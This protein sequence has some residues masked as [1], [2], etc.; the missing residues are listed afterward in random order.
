MV[1]L[2]TLG[3]LA[4]LGLLGLPDY[5]KDGLRTHSE[6]FSTRTDPWSSDHDHDGLLDGFEARHGLDPRRADPDGDGLPDDAELAAGADPF[7]WD[8]DHD[9]LNDRLEVVLGL[10]PVRPDSDDDGLPDAAEF[11]FGTDPLVADTDHDGL[12]DGA[13]SGRGTRPLHP[14]SDGDW[15]LDGAEVHRHRTDP[16]DD[17]SDDDLLDDAREVQAA[18][19]PLDADTDDDGLVDGDEVDRHGTDPLRADTDS[20]GLLDPA[21]LGLGS[22]PLDPDSDDD[23]LMDGLEPVP[24][25]FVADCD[26]DG[27]DDATEF[28]LELDLQDA[29]TVGDLLDTTLVRLDLADASARADT[30]GDGIPDGLETSGLIEW[31]PFRPQVG[32]TDYLVEMV[33]VTTPE[34]AGLDWASFGG[35]YDQVAEA[36]QGG[37]IAMQW[38][39]TDLAVRE[40]PR[41]F[42][43]DRFLASHGDHLISSSN[44]FVHVVLLTPA[45]QLTADVG[46]GVGGW[47]GYYDQHGLVVYGTHVLV[48]LEPAGSK[49]YLQLFPQ[50][51]L[52]ADACPGMTG[53]YHLPSQRF[54]LSWESGLDAG[55]VSWDGWLVDDASG[56]LQ[57]PGLPDANVSVGQYF[58]A[59]QALADTILHEIG[60]NM[61]LCHTHEEDCYTSLP[62]HEQAL[63]HTSTM[64]YESD[65][66]L[67]LLPSQWERFRT[68]LACSHSGNL[69]ALTLGGLSDYRFTG[70]EPTGAD[71]D[72][73]DPRRCG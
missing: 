56:Q 9:G 34:T 67:H 14:D 24:C 66:P 28:G 17:D 29:T 62:P 53:T 13:E 6:V 54:S 71:A 46:Q 72:L 1:V 27:V 70:E 65:F 21:E 68:Q 49:E 8:T 73:F 7:Q 35:A 58:L 16:L 47:A 2:I 4:G 12:M 38:T 43:Q 61:G 39:E 50:Q 32:R 69:N 20:D 25:L 57:R 19:N 60:H 11:A 22:D 44:P 59:Q 33:R 15:L 55:T 40:V 63:R 42:G 64:S 10:D 18:T 37:Q 45:Y 23:G 26:D 5:D 41:L 48:S 30:D 36:V 51:C 52:L 31:G 3:A